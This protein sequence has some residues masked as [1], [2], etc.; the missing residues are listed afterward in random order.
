MV[1][2][3]LVPIDLFD[4]TSCVVFFKTV[5]IHEMF[6]QCFRG[7]NFICTFFKVV[8]MKIKICYSLYKPRE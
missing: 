8:H 4:S 6:L 5:M 1:I 2:V 7:I 3:W